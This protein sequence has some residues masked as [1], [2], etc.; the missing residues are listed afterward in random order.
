[1]KVEIKK[2][3]L[4]DIKKQKNNQLELSIKKFIN[5]VL[6]AENLLEISNIKKLSGYQK[7][8]RVRLG[9]YRLGLFVENETLYFVRCLHRKEIYKFFP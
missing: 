7:F 8:Y 5:Q 2:S 1:M 3:F 9:D 6:E 4:K